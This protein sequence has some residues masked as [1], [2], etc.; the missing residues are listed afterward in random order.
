M[1]KLTNTKGAGSVGASDERWGAGPAT[2]QDTA[3]GVC[4]NCG[5]P[6]WLEGLWGWLHRDGTYLCRN[7]ETSEVLCSPAEP[8]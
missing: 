4:K 5:Q 1:V 6:V 3:S 8:R 2:Y 7:A